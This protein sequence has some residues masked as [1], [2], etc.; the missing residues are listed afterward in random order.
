MIA[1]I[2][3]KRNSGPA[4]VILHDDWVWRDKATGEPERV[5]NLLFPIP[6]SP[7]DGEPG[8]WE[9]HQVAEYLGGKIAYLRP[10][11]DYDPDVIF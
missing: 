6:G 3:F 2:D 9:A 8:H 4:T 5:L 1:S 11:P 7:A 10:V